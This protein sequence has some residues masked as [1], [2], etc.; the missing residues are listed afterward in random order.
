M[1]FDA[2]MRTSPVHV[3]PSLAGLSS[4]ELEV[5]RRDGE[6][7]RHG[8]PGYEC[9][10]PIGIAPSRADR[11][12]CLAGLARPGR[13]F[14]HA[15]AHWLRAGGPAPDRIRIARGSGRRPAQPLPRVEWSYRRFAP[16]EVELLDGTIA[17]TSAAR[18]AADLA[19]EHDAAAV[20]PA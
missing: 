11:L 19:A 17:V 15:T 9:W 12:A 16:D 20:A 3:H 7:Q 6:V 13:V 8:P 14:T 10:L 1:R 4:L 2:G 5:M 18:T